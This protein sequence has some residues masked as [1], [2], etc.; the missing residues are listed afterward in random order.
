MLKSIMP[1][2]KARLVYSTD[3][4]FPRKEKPAGKA[5][6]TKSPLSQQK[7]YVRLDRK[8]RGGKSVTLIAGIQ[9]PGKDREA[10][11]KQLKAKLGTGGALK[12]DVLEIQG[13][14]CDVIIA[15]LQGMGY[16]PK[17]A[18]G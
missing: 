15:M 1:E 6:Q 12:N 17:R 8:R 13:D 11:L 3:K 10:L 14:Q 4:V 2:E 5:S 9:M 16:K 18:G 7:I